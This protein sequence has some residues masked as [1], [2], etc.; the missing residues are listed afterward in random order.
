M[1]KR[2]PREVCACVTCDEAWRRHP[3]RLRQ[4]MQYQRTNRSTHASR[5][6]D[7]A[8]WDWLAASVPPL[9]RGR[10][11]YPPE[12]AQ[13]RPRARPST[14]CADPRGH[15]AAGRAPSVRIP[16][17]AGRLASLRA[18]QRMAACIDVAFGLVTK[19]SATNR[20]SPL[21]G[22]GLRPPMHLRTLQRHRPIRRRNQHPRHA[23]HR[24][25][26][27]PG[28]PEKAPCESVLPRL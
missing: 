28:E 16:K 6:F 10:P 18:A 22:G 23:M 9:A 20:L 21:P 7:L 12:A 8:Y 17:P 1:R 14:G 26:P 5:L 15:C 24:Y 11:R 3:G 19:I 13:A 4:E 25:T 2:R 27:T